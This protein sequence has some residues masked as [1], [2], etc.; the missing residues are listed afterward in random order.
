MELCR[1]RIVCIWKN[2]YAYAPSFI[3]LSLNSHDVQYVACA[4]IFFHIIFNCTI[5]VH[6]CITGSFRRWKINASLNPK[7]LI[8]MKIFV[9]TWNNNKLHY[10]I[11]TQ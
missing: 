4:R 9:C 7:I 8:L 10:N 11:I 3:D 5:Y 2:S 6:V 1:G